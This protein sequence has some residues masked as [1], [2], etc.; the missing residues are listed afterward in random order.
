M[1]TGSSG[2]C[3]WWISTARE[4]A[5]PTARRTS[6]SSDSSTPPRRGVHIDLAL[7]VNDLDA[8]L[9]VAVQ[10]QIHELLQ[11][12]GGVISARRGDPARNS[13]TLR[14]H[15]YTKSWRQHERL[16]DATLEVLCQ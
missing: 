4:Q 6:S 9:V 1:R 11:R 5:S 3:R 2:Q 13:T 10:L 16:A 7:D 8:V 12:H 14:V 15:L